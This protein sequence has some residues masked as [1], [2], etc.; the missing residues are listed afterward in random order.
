MEMALSSTVQEADHVGFGHDVGRKWVWQ[1][2]IIAGLMVLLYWRVLIDLVSDWWHYDSQSHGLLIPPMA[3]YLAWMRRS[4]TF[5]QPVAPENRGLWVILAGCVVFALGILGAEPFLS[6]ISLVIILTGFVWTY[7]GKRRLRTL[8]FPLIL[9]ATMVPLPALIYNALAAP[10]QLFASSVS[11]QLAQT[12]GI[13]LYRD[14]NVIQLAHISLGVAEACSGLHSLSA[15]VIASLLLAY[16]HCTGKV[17]RIV[18][19][20]I[21]VPMAIAVNVVRVTGTALAADY[22]EELAMGFYH[23]FSGWLVFVGGFGALYLASKLIN[24]F[25]KI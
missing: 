3:A 16:L 10:L 24:R 22:N 4:L 21:S 13:S 2:A 15:L 6:R 23:A 17:A 12:I 11:S 9:L 1:A 5:S 25:V 14:G 8:A 20:L 19:V 18:V 7:W